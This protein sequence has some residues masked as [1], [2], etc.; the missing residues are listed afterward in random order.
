MNLV[1]EIYSG[2][3]SALKESGDPSGGPSSVTNELCDL[4]QTSSFSGL[5]FYH[6]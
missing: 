1:F 6:L 5:Q 3:I 2:E 4:G